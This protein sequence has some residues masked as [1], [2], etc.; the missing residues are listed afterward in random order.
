MLSNESKKILII[1]LGEDM[2]TFG[3]K[4]GEFLGKKYKEKTFDVSNKIETFSKYDQQIILCKE[5]I[6]REELNQ[7]LRRL[8]FYEN[9]IVGWFLIED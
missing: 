5:G 1:T 4:F 3:T 2:N 8:K 7:F 6:N 9:N